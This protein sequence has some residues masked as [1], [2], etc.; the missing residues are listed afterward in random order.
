MNA[1]HTPESIKNEVRTMIAEMTERA[2]SEISDTAHFTDDL[3][4]DSL[5]ALEMMVAVNKKYRIQLFEE[6][7]STIKTLNDAVAVVLRHVSPASTNG[8]SAAVSK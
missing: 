1:A 4:L 8:A 5:M 6:E 3:E 2:P 7:F